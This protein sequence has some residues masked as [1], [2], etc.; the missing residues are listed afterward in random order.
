M[1][2]DIVII[3]VNYKMKEKILAMQESLLRDVRGLPLRV[4]LVVID[5]ASGDGIAEALQE[6]FPV[7]RCISNPK[8]IGFGA[9]NNL[10]LKQFESKYYFL[11][12]PDI[13]FPAGPSVI[14]RLYEFMEN[15]PKAGL[16]SPK[17]ILDNGKIQP[18]CMRFPKFWDQ[19]LYRLGFHK[20]Y[21]LAKRKVEDF[22]MSDFSHARVLPVDWVTGAAMLIRASALK[23]TGHF[24]ERFFM[25][26]EDCDLCRRMWDAKW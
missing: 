6:K 24:D 20:K 18:S 17:L 1:E 7:A 22:L 23:D 21:N 9:A 16:I 14:W 2:F 5:N 12:N 25:Y 26:F 3:T 11:I 4:Q 19:P 13:I 10:V 15:N 8:N